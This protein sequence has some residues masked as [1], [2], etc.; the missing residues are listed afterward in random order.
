MRNNRN[1]NNGFLVIELFERELSK[2]I[3]LQMLYHD[4]DLLQNP[5]K[6]SVNALIFLTANPHHI[7]LYE[8]QNICQ[9]VSKKKVKGA[10]GENL[11]RPL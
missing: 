7:S 5:N 4:V 6:H 10:S 11:Q 2:T 8:L 9:G 3:L 1:L